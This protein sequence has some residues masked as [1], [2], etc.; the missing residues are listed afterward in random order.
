MVQFHVR[1]L[2]VSRARKNDHPNARDKER[3]VLMD[4]VPI[5]WLKPFGRDQYYTL[6][7]SEDHEVALIPEDGGPDTTPVV[8]FKL[9]RNDGQLV[10][11]V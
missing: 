11:Y 7:E 9:V 1:I 5:Q 4:G 6:T 2:P 10:V 3:N 8:F